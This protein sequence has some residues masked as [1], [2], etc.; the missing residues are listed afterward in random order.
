M[1]CAQVPFQRRKQC[2]VRLQDFIRANIE[3]I[4]V[5]W[6]AFARTQSAAG[7]MTRTELRD[8]AGAILRHIARDLGTPQTD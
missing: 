8:H 6:T 4:L 7:G 5:E 3:P 2:N 1:A